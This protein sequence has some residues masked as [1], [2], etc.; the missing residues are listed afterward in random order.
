MFGR[1]TRVRPNSSGGAVWAR[2]RF[3]ANPYNGQCYAC[4]FD[5]CNCHEVCGIRLCM[6]PFPNPC[7]CC[8]DQIVCVN[9]DEYAVVTN[10]SK[11]EYVAEPGMHYLRNACKMCSSITI[12]GRVS[13]RLR[14]V[15]VRVETK[16]RDDVFVTL[17]VSVQYVV[18]DVMKAFYQ[19]AEPRQQIRSYVEDSVRVFVSRVPLDEIF[20]MQQELTRHILE[21]IKPKM[22][23][24]GW[25][26]E[27]VPVT[28]LSP[29]R[30]VQDAMN[31]INIQARLKE[32]EKTNAEANKLIQ[33]KRAEAAAEATYL[34]GEG[35]SR[36]RRALLQ[37]Y[38]SMIADL[39]EETGLTEK[40]AENTVYTQQL[41]TMLADL[42][43]DNSPD[44][45]FLSHQP[46]E[47][48]RLRKDLQEGIF[49]SVDS[50]AAAHFQ[51]P[52]DAVDKAGGFAAYRAF[53]EVPEYKARSQ[54]PVPVFTTSMAV[55][56]TA[57]P[58]EEMDGRGGDGVFYASAV[59]VPGTSPSDA[60]MAA[61]PVARGFKH[62]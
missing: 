8:C 33:I 32:A 29:E 50:A 27:D 9:Q 1:R 36:M 14:S 46:G 57:P 34:A 49:G 18:A 20:F 16:T 10:Y 53:R 48:F 31:Q 41:F 17:A 35:V 5:P 55:N 19:L 13:T 47:V 21:S 24:F 25:Q 62:E 52:A 61:G 6:C 44:K 22:E 43:T 59:V 30:K 28:D 45:L 40:I 2:N 37:G 58:L 15:E 4:I 51:F 7:C 12:E 56:P 38:N 39:I 42:A 23:E 11:P 60:K 3:L 26:I 54:P